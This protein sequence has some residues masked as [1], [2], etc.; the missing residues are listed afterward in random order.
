MVAALRQWV[1]SDVGERPVIN[2]C[3]NMP[4]GTAAIF[5]ADCEQDVTTNH[6]GEEFR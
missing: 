5:A 2:I 1:D 6:A 3:P 4:Q